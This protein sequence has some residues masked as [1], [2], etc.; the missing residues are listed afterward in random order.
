MST[1]RYPFKPYFPKGEVGKLPK[2]K[3][4]HCGGV[5]KRKLGNA[6]SRVGP[7]SSRRKA[8]IAQ[9]TRKLPL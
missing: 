7:Y 9:C 2:G 5:K 1:L 6:R 3:T 4:E 8:S